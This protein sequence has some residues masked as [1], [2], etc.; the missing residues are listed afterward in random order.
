MQ[1]HD[2]LTH[3]T[4]LFTCASQCAE[5]TAFYMYSVC[6]CNLRLRVRAASSR[7]S[8]FFFFFSPKIND[9]GF[10]NFGGSVLDENIRHLCCS[11]SRRIT[12]YYLFV[13]FEHMYICYCVLQIL[14][15]ARLLWW[16]IIPRLGTLS[17]SFCNPSYDRS[18]ASFKACFPKSA[19][20]CLRFQFPV[21]FLLI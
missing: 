7:H 6:W 5:V 3:S 15:T 11:P 4:P 19:I 17:S 9:G 1:N 2:C 10:W 12:Y 21:S 20:Q 18:I 13:L 16:L 14:W 8:F